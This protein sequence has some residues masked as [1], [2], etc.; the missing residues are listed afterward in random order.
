MERVYLDH[1]DEFVNWFKG[2]YRLTSDE[3]LDHYQD[4]IT[5]FFEKVISGNLEEVQSSIKTY[6]FGM[7]KNRMLQKFQQQTRKDRHNVNLL[8]HYTFL[9]EDDHSKSVFENASDT[10]GRI[11]DELNESCR[12]ILRLFY[13]EKKSMSEIAQILGHKNEGVSR[14]TKK[15]CMEKVRDAVIDN[16]KE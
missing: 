6:L 14:T 10:L 1:R 4:I 12:E 13:F 16:N 8:E 3:A 2:K 9:A 11:F 15:R 5:I 7:G